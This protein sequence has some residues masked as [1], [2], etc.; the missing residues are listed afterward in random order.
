ML[1]G[2]GSRQKRWQEVKMVDCWVVIHGGSVVIRW[3]S[4]GVNGGGIFVELKPQILSL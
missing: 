1:D 2:G 4:N 3:W